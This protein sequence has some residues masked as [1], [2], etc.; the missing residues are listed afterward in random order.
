M[1]ASSGLEAGVRRVCEAVSQF[2]KGLPRQ[3]AQRL[4]SHRNDRRW[5]VVEPYHHGFGWKGLLEL[6]V[7]GGAVEVSNADTPFAVD[8]DSRVVGVFGKDRCPSDDVFD[9]A[10]L[11]FGRGEHGI[12]LSDCQATGSLTMDRSLARLDRLNII[13]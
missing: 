9:A 10:L 6:Q 8:G 4:A 12:S 13:A 1:K 2:A 5:L 7:Q 3:D 11:P